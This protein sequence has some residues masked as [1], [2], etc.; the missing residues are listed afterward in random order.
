MMNV[1]I[2]YKNA[3]PTDVMCVAFYPNEG[4]YRGW[5]IDKDNRIVGDFTADDSK[6]MERRL[7]EIIGG[8]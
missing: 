2:W 5:L 3:R 1:D 7:E 6:Q 8:R 4:K